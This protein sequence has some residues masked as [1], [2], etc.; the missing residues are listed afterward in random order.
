MPNRRLKTVPGPTSSPPCKP[1]LTAILTLSQSVIASAAA[2]SEYLNKEIF[3][4]LSQPKLTMRPKAH[5]LEAVV[6]G[7]AIDE[8]QIR[9]K[10][11]ITMIVPFAG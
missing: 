3:R 11:A 5:K 6:V 7:L 9:L 10:V 8:N 4:T 2:T 1:L